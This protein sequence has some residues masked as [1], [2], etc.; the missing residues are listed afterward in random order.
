MTA[1]KKLGS[2]YLKI[3]FRRDARRL[4][5]EFVMCLLSAVALRSLIGQGMSGLCPAECWE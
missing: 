3:E 5:E 2:Q 4:I 1:L